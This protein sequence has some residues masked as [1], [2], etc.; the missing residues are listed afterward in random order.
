MTVELTVDDRDAAPRG[1]DAESRQR[2]T[3]KSP[4]LVSPV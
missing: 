4:E 3:L 1:Q 2:N